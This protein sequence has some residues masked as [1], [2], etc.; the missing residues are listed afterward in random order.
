MYLKSLV[1]NYKK[2]PYTGIAATLLGM[3]EDNNGNRESAIEYYKKADKEKKF[4]NM[5]E[6]ISSCLKEPYNPLKQILI[7]NDFF[8]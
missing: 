2:N 5:K 8:E 4:G 7:L 1:E 3:M 6:I